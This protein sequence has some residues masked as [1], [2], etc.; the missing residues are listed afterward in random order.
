MNGVFGISGT[1]SNDLGGWGVTFW[2]LNFGHLTP[3]P[4]TPFLPGLLGSYLEYIFF[5]Q[6]HFGPAEPQIFENQR[7]SACNCCLKMSQN[8]KIK[9]LAGFLA[10]FNQFSYIWAL[11]WLKHLAT[12]DPHFEHFPDQLVAQLENGVTDKKCV[13]VSSL[14]GSCDFTC[15]H[16][17]KLKNE[18]TLESNHFSDYHS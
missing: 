16:G 7:N 11:N 2:F 14:Q 9:E 1:K 18:P 10:T 8:E 17:V 15:T 12:V 5:K 4:T 13:A 6:L 3:T